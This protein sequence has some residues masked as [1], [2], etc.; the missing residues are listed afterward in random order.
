MPV[1]PRVAMT[2]D[3]NY[4]SDS[5]VDLGPETRPL[6]SRQQI[7]REPAIKISREELV[8]NDIMPSEAPD[9]G[10]TLSGMFRRKSWIF[11][12]KLEPILM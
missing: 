3:D 12:G 4:K 11:D 10:A 5:T 6:P 8:S 7:S 2:E 9:S 1:S